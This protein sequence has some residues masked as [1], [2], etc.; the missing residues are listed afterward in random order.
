MF[1]C[2]KDGKGKGVAWVVSLL[3]GAPQTV[4]TGCRVA[5]P[6]KGDYLSWLLGLRASKQLLFV[7]LVGCGSGNR[8]QG[9][10]GEKGGGRCSIEGNGSSGRKPE[11]ELPSGRMTFHTDITCTLRYLSY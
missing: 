9:L 2:R 7:G 4:Q 6:F 5:Q 11:V 10:P 8:Q 1:H 3:G